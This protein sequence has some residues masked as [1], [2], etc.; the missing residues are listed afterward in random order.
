MAGKEQLRLNTTPETLRN[1]VEMSDEFAGAYKN[2]FRGAERERQTMVQNEVARRLQLLPPTARP[3][4]HDRVLLEVEASLEPINEANLQRGVIAKFIEAQVRN[5]P[6]WQAK[7]IDDSTYDSVEDFLGKMYP[8]MF[9]KYAKADPTKELSET[10]NVAYQERMAREKALSADPQS[11]PEEIPGKKFKHFQEDWATPTPEQVQTALE[12]AESD[13]KWG[14]GLERISRGTE[15]IMHGLSGKKGQGLYQTKMQKLPVAQYMRYTQ[16]LEG[17]LI[18]KEKL[19]E[20]MV[21]EQINESTRITDIAYESQ[22]EEL[23]LRAERIQRAKDY[24]ISNLPKKQRKA[25]EAED[26]E[27]KANARENA[28]RIR[29]EIKK[30]LESQGITDHET[31]EI[32]RYI[33]TTLNNPKVLK[34]MG[35]EE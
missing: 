6:E 33:E 13:M 30:Y 18:E 3:L 25:K 15:A 12:I 34:E 32:K 14:G 4:Q 7:W 21:Q 9:K 24:M 17:A 8:L 27:S 16:V 23:E 19:K 1:M 31:D 11:E 10:N 35:I 2:V 28:R 26:R 5:S 29:K 20:Q 22:M